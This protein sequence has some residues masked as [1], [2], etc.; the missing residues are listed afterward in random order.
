[1]HLTNALL[2]LKSKEPPK[3]SHAE[4]DPPL[5]GRVRVFPDKVPV[6]ELFIL[7]GKIPLTVIVEPLVINV[8]VS[9]LER[10]P[11]GQFVRD[12]PWPWIMPAQL[13]DKSN[14]SGFV[15]DG[16]ESVDSS[17]EQLVNKNKHAINP[18][19]NF[20]FIIEL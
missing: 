17:F 12:V 8:I 9:L 1:V 3:K 4:L 16:V 20:P 11:A 14:K 6:N 18:S 19:S 7:L 10:R 15:V 2:S 5:N 13:P